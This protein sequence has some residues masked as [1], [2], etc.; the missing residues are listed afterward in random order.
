MLSRTCWRKS[1]S[2][3]SGRTLRRRWLTLSTCSRAGGGSSRRSVASA[4]VRLKASGLVQVYVEARAKEAAS[5]QLKWRGC[6]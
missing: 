2:L 3:R 1:T 4:S 6:V 5:W